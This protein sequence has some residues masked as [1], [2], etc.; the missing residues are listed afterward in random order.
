MGAHGLRLFLVGK[1]VAG[2]IEAARNGS[3]GL[4]WK[5]IDSHFMI[6]TGTVS[7]TLS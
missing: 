6:Q 7:I 3:S 1:K 4:Q 2:K 5:V